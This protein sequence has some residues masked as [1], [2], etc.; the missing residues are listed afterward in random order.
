M[1]ADVALAERKVVFRSIRHWLWIHPRANS[2]SRSS[3]IPE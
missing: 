2:S 1:I 3:P